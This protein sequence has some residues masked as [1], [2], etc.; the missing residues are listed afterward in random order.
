[1]SPLGARNATFAHERGLGQIMGYRNDP[2]GN[3]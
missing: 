1:M 3:A 2:G